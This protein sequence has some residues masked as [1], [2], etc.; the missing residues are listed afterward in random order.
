MYLFLIF[1]NTIFLS[2]FFLFCLQG[3]MYLFIH[4]ICFYSNIFGYETKVLFYSLLL[5][6]NPIQSFIYF[7]PHCLLACFNV[8]SF[9]FL[10]QKIIPFAEIS[11]VKRAKT[12]GIFPNAIEILA[13][14][15][16]VSSPLLSSLLYFPSFPHSPD[17]PCFSTFLHPF[18]PVMKLSSLSMMDGLNMVLLSN[19]K[20][21]FRFP[22]NPLPLIHCL[23]LLSL[24]LTFTLQDSLSESNNDGLVNRVLTTLDLATDLDSPSRFFV[25]S[26]YMLYLLPLTASCLTILHFSGMKHLIFLAVPVFLLLVKMAF[27]LHP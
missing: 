1:L 19:Q 13:G 2:P 5:Q 9:L 15:K 6:S 7:L 17:F 23:L 16:K 18:F 24:I 25:S 20:P 26:F 21:S 8:L 3:H 27:H 11:S 10:F 4:Y 22:N 14:G 12:A